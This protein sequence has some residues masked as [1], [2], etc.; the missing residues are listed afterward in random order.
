MDHRQ[1]DVHDTVLSEIE[2]WGYGTPQCIDSAAQSHKLPPLCTSYS[3]YL[4]DSLLSNNLTRIMYCCQARLVYIPNALWLKM[5][6]SVQIF[7]NILTL[8]RLK[9]VI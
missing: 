9:L 6:A 7:Q 5:K 4:F 2:H 8:M 3:T 1:Q